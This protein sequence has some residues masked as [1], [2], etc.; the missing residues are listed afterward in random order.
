M[1]QITT[2][3]VGTIVA[4]KA[5][6]NELDFVK[7]ANNSWSSPRLFLLSIE[8]GTL[9][10]PLHTEADAVKQQF[11]KTFF[12]SSF[13]SMILLLDIKRVHFYAYYQLWREG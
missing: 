11:I 3:C 10:L 2:L 5:S 4:A 6:V 13:S 7:H 12:V 1:S 9:L 8:R